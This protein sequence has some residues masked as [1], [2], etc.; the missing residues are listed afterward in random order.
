LK[1]QFT[2]SFSYFSIRTEALSCFYRCF[3]YLSNRILVLW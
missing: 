1:A 3:S 2:I